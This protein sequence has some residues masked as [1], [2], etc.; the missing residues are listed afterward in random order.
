MQRLNHKV[1]RRNRAGLSEWRSR[2]FSLW[3]ATGR[4]REA[5]D[6]H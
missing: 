4:K 6:E 1:V 3:P 2:G 5:V